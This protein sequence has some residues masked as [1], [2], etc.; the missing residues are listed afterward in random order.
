MARAVEVLK[1]AQ[2]RLRALLEGRV[3]A[4]LQ[5]YLAQARDFFFEERKV[6]IFLFDPGLGST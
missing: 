4:L 6:R 5:R 3:T 1:G 2:T